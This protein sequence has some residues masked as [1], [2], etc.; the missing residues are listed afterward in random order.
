MGIH[1]LLGIVE[2]D[3]SGIPASRSQATD[4][5]SKIDAIGSPLALNRAVMHGEGHCVALAQGNNFWP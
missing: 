4:T 3:A 1:S 2:D 5:M